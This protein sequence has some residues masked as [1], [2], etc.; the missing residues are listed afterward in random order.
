MDMIGSCCGVLP[1]LLQHPSLSPG[2]K[3][4]SPLQCLCAGLAHL[5]WDL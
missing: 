5:V 1:K 3:W 4:L 2:F